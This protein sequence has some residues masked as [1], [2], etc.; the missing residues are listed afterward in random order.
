MKTT[1]RCLDHFSCNC[2]G[3]PIVGLLILLLIGIT[4]T[5]AR[6]LIEVGYGNSPVRDDNWPAG[7]VDVANLP[8]RCAW[9]EGPPYGGGQSNFLYRGDAAA[10]QQVI[11]TFAKIKA[12]ALE[13]RIHDGGQI[14]ISFLNDPNDAGS[15]DHFDWSFTVWNPRNWNSLY[16]NP[17]SQHSAE[18]PGGSFREQV[19]APTLVV[20]VGGEKGIDFSKV[21]IPTGITV[22]D[23]RAD[24]NGFPGGSVIVDD[25]FDMVTSKPVGGAK[26]AFAHQRAWDEW[27]ETT[28]GTSNADGHFELKSQVKGFFGVT[29]SADGYAPRLLG[30]VELRGNTFR[31]FTAHLSPGAT[32]AGNAVD[33]DG[34]PVAGVDVHALCTM[35]IDG[36]GYI[37]PGKR[38]TKTNE[39]GDFVLTDLPTGYTQLLTGSDHYAGMEMLK[40][41]SVPDQHLII[42][43]TATGAIKGRVLDS[44]GHPASRGVVNID[45]PGTPADRNGK[46]GGSSGTATDGT[47][48]FENVPPGQ[49]IVTAMATNPGH[50]PSGNDPHAKTITVKADETVE[51]EVTGR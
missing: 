2:I 34:K 50:A 40:L 37:L 48:H 14:E 5:P 25:V 12:P 7:S 17:A 20:Y 27:E 42:R 10:F 44:A 24:A 16:N 36:R 46:W 49:Y 18:D 4:I 35:S 32:L 9:W 6:A 3:S 1:S 11:D 43:L 26:I 31:R 23:E 33:T 30:D 15:D 8:T 13:L 41:Y 22:N 51:V 28:T 21:K 47:F 38:E 29:V 19:D 39:H 45:P